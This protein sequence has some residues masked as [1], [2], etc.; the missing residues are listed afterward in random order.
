MTRT[1]ARSQRL[2]GPPFPSML[3]LTQ[4]VRVLGEPGVRMGETIASQMLFALLECRDEVAEPGAPP[5]A[6]VKLPATGVQPER[7]PS[8]PKSSRPLAP[9]ASAVRLSER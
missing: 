2:P 9:C 5:G 3:K 7:S 4:R 1:T 8:N 6:T